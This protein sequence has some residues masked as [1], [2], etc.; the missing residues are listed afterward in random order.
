V[1]KLTKADPHVDYMG[2]ERGPFK[3]ANCE[4]FLPP[5][6]C[7]NVKG[8][9]DTEACCNLFERKKVRPRTMAHSDLKWL[10]L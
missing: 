1:A 3:C 4:H 5:S 9:I 7:E 10:E 6:A 8:P 2:R